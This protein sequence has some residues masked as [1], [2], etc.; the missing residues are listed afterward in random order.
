MGFVGFYSSSLATVSIISPNLFIPSL[1]RVFFRCLHVASV[2][3]VAVAGHGG[4]TFSDIDCTMPTA[5][6]TSKSG[7]SSR[8]LSIASTYTVRT[9]LRGCKIRAG[10]AGSDH[11]LSLPLGGTFNISRSNAEA[12]T[13]LCTSAGRAYSFSP[14]VQVQAEDG[15]ITY[16]RLHQWEFCG[17]RKTAK[18]GNIL[19]R[20]MSYFS[21][22]ADVRRSRGVCS[23]NNDGIILKPGF[24]NLL[25]HLGGLRVWLFYHKDWAVPVFRTGSILDTG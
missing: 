18:I 11:R 2:P 17:D 19:R 1:I 7:S 6:R 21:F 13:V 22:P 5:E 10:P 9:V 24:Q 12:C 20:R 8:G 23:K 14:V 25:S 16:R 4:L 15:S 3:P